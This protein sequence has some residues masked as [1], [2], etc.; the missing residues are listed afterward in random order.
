[1][2][3]DEEIKAAHNRI[4]SGADM[5]QYHQELKTLGVIRYVVHSGAGTTVY[6]G[7]H[8]DTLT[9]E[10]RYETIG[11]ADIPSK[12]ALKQ[13][14]HAQQ[15]GQTDYPAFCHQMAEAGI[16]K[17]VINLR[18]MQVVYLDMGGYEVLAE[19]VAGR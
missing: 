9:T 17:W 8:G 4:Q 18:T 11:V 15:K 7:K 2:I 6:T 14:L 19:R 12:V 16:A 3:K 1:M 13:A 5:A 10:P